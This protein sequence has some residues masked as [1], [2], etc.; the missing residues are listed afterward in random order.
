MTTAAWRQLEHVIHGAVATRASQ[1][2]DVPEPVARYFRAAMPDGSGAS[3]AAVLEMRGEIKIGRWLPFRAR[4]LLAPRYGTVWEATVARMI[5]GSDRYVAGT[6][7]MD[8]KLFGLIPFVRAGGPDVTRSAAERAAGESIWAPA[9][10]A[11]GTGTTWTA[12]SA[13]RISAEVDTDGHVVRVEHHIDDEGCLIESSFMR[14]GDPDRTGRWGE[15][16]FGV[17]VDGHRRFGGVHIPAQGQAGWHFGTDR[18]NDG[19]FFRFEIT[20]H[21]ALDAAC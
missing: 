21:R 11:P 18:W 12:A 4:Q 19:V 16:P 14:W 13:D 5:V 17:Q 3:S 15:H 7:G 8:W 20:S 1:P 10:V 6:G 9:A 2:T